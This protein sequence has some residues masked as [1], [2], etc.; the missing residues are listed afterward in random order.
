MISTAYWFFRGALESSLSFLDRIF[1]KLF[2]SEYNPLYKSGTIAVVMLAIASVSGLILLFFYRVGSPYESMQAIQSNLWLGRW[3]RGIHRFSSD[4]ML[5]ATLVHLIRMFI[6]KKSWG[7]RVLAWVSGVFLLGFI[8]LTAWTGFV[9]VWD[10][11]AQVLAITFSKI[12]DATGVLPDPLSLAFD[13]SQDKPPSAFFFMI[14]FV[15]VV[16]PL[17]MIFG[18]WI[19]TAKMA[20]ASWF[21]PKKLFLGLV[22]LFL[23]I[24]LIIP[25]PLGY[26]GD[27]LRLASEYPLNWFYNFWLI[28][29]DSSSVLFLGAIVFILIGLILIPL[30]L[31]P[32]KKEI[33]APSDL[34]ESRCHGCE[35]CVVDC[36]YEAISMQA[37]SDGKLHLS[38]LVASVDPSLCVSCGLC[39]ASCGPMTIGPPGRKGSDQ[40]KLGKE[41]IEQLRTKG[42]DLSEQNVVIGCVN[43]PYTE[44]RLQKWTSQSKDTKFYPV[45]C[46]GSLHMATIGYLAFYFKSVKLAACAERNCTNKDAF[47]LL[48]DRLSGERIPGLPGRVDPTRVSLYSIGDGEES[49]LFGSAKVSNAQRA[50]ILLSSLALMFAIALLS[51]TNWTPP[52]TDAGLLRL[53][54]RLTGQTIEDCRT[55]SAEELSRLPIHMQKPE[56]CSQTFVS[57]RLNVLIDDKKV[58]SKTIEPSGFREDGPIYVSEEIQVKPGLRDV[59]LYFEPI[60]TKNKERNELVKLNLEEQIAFEK[61][62]VTLLYLKA[63]Q[64]SLEKRR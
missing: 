33:P 19:H 56:D 18:I 31:R 30:V 3:I 29:D 41:M 21:P 48:R 54:W 50:N 36:P 13:G 9:L 32:K 46:M 27:L 17:A 6:Q 38:E 1:N 23:I 8:L 37:R 26:S 15:H 10:A 35:Q 51:G 11:Q 16:I 59:S 25:A 43:Q 49:K 7:K 28:G 14:L 39:A 61:D 55:L 47:M 64:S 4:A 5:L 57:Y 40:Y 62:Q 2:T 53:S 58:L 63:D 42:E 44:K 52:S 45:Q 12:I 20:R 22:A 34:D 24:S 60:D